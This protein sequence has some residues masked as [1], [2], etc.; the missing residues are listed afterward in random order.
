MKGK[1]IAICRSDY[2]GKAKQPIDFGFFREGWGL[3]GDAHAGTVKE[4]SLLLKSQLESLARETGMVFP[5]GAFAENLLI[6]GLPQE[7]LIPS[8]RLCIGS[9]I[10]Q[11][12]KVGKEPDKSH[13]YHYYGYSLLPR[14]GV[15]AQVKQ[16]GWVVVGDEIELSEGDLE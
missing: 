14:F 9:L 13:S 1:I 3:I 10:L 15:F 8:R 2:R 6:E 5:P 12:T 16:S 7:D 4:V 11:I